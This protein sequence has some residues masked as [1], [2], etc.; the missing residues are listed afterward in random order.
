MRFGSYLKDQEQQL[1][2]LKLEE[3][4]EDE[5]EIKSFSE[6]QLVKVVTNND[7]NFKILDINIEN[8][9]PYKNQPFQSYDEEKEKEMIE[10]IK[11]SGILQEPI[12]REI[13]DEKYEILAGHNR[14]NCAKKVGFN[15]VKCKVVNVTEEQ[16]KLIMIET[17]LITRKN[18]SVIETAK[19][20]KI[21][22]EALRNSPATDNIRNYLNNFSNMSQGNVQR[23]LRINYLNESLQNMVQDKKISL[24]VAERLSFLNNEEQNTLT[25]YLREKNITKISEKQ[26]KLLKDES[27]KKVLDGNIIDKIIRN[28]NTKKDNIV[29]TFSRKEIN[30]LFNNID[31]EK[32]IKRIIIKEFNNKLK[33]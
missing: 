7:R 15:K 12:V 31:D 21:K 26:S 23:Y 18:L 2:N 22:Y 27:S 20:L 4:N 25:D 3:K 6:E 13:K 10:S 16:A 5:K 11:I 28:E 8:L 30:K 32:K 14:I 19:A 24:K 29:I 1:N 17:N 9:I 33:V